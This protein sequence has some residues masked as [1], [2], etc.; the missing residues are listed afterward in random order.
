MKALRKIVPSILI[1][2]VLVMAAGWNV[3]PNDD[4]LAQG[5]MHFAKNVYIGNNGNGALFLNNT[6]VTA[7][8]DNLNSGLASSTANIVSNSTLKVYGSNLVL[9][10]G[11]TI[12]LP[13]ASIASTALPAAIANS[14][15][16][17]NPVLK[18]YGS[19]IEVVANGSLTVGGSAGLSLAVTNSST[20]STNVMTFVNGVLVTC[21]RNP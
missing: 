7:T 3:L 18:V 4:T 19:N 15:L 11:G 10:T 12:S 21:T 8:A 2:L 5:P 17:S 1:G 6:Q 16:V 20:M 9:V 13:S 14:T